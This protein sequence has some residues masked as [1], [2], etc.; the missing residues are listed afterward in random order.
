MHQAIG[1]AEDSR[2]INSSNS[3]L[4]LDEED[5]RYLAA[6]RDP[7]HVVTKSTRHPIGLFS[8]VAFI[9]QQMLGMYTDFRSC[10]FETNKLR[11]RN[12]SNTMDCHA[13]HTER[14]DF[15]D[16][17]VRGCSHGDGWS[18]PLHRVWTCPATASH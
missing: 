2:S 5:R 13:S 1:V 3:S 14:W 10:L 4:D 17:L 8:V 6:L 9:L 18:C 11:H 12:L 7:N 16:L 15:D